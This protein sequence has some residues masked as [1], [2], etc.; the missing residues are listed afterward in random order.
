MKHNYEYSS[1]I[2]QELGGMSNRPV[3][4]QCPMKML[5]LSQKF[6]SQ[7]RTPAVA[8]TLL[9][10]Q[11]SKSMHKSAVLTPFCQELDDNMR[12]S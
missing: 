8:H 12:R 5:P 7:K 6:L 4:M 1:M 9:R 3:V 10:P 11:R 2:L